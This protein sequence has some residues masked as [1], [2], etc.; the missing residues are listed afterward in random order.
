MLSQN[1]DYMIHVHLQDSKVDVNNIDTPTKHNNFNNLCFH[2]NKQLLDNFDIHTLKSSQYNVIKKFLWDVYHK[3]NP[4]KED[5]IVCY[6]HHRLQSILFNPWNTT[7][8]ERDF[9][10]IISKTLETTNHS[11][12]K[13]INKIIKSTLAHCQTEHGTKHGTENTVLQTLKDFWYCEDELDGLSNDKLKLKLQHH[14]LNQILTVLD[15][16]GNEFS[17]LQD[18]KDIIEKY[19]Q[20]QEKI[21]HTWNKIIIKENKK[22]PKKPLLKREKI[23]LS[24]I[25]HYRDEYNEHKH[26]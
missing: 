3:E 9:S 12:Y 11:L 20:E 26:Q 24:K 1:K 19:K 18:K 23:H 16:P 17:S 15:L 13:Q 22:K 6:V 8:V 21:I 2:I 4:T 14:K 10:R 25:H 7:T 5:I